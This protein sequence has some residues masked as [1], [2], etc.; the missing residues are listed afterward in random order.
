MRGASLAPWPL[1]QPFSPAVVIGNVHR[2]FRARDLVRAAGCLQLTTARSPRG[3]HQPPVLSIPERPTVASMRVWQ[4]IIHWSRTSAPLSA[5]MSFCFRMAR[6]SVRFHSGL[7][8]IRSNFA[9]M[10]LS[11]AWLSRVVSFYSPVPVTSKMEH[12]ARALAF[13]HEGSSQ[14]IPPKS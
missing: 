10:A 12:S 8:A 14:A 1:L 11:P 2:R 9:R 4:S 3:N 5:C 7:F 13:R 6:A